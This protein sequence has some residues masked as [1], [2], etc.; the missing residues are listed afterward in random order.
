MDD[1]IRLLIK[2]IKTG[3][4]EAFKKLFLEYYD[5]LSNFAWRYIKSV[6]IA[7]E[8]VQEAFL[9]IWESREM[10]DSSKNIKSYLYQIVRNKALN[11]LKHKDVVEKYNTQI[12]WLNSVSI[13]QMHDFDEQPEFIEAAQEAIESLPDGARR[14]Y[15]LHRKDGLTYKEIAEVLDISIRTVESQM[16]RALEKLRNN[17]SEYLSDKSSLPV[18]E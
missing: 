16:S 10:L 6:H 2:K 8:L 15:K 12:D 5:P 4:K 11:H 9:S 13:S 14:I 3:D 7:E 18:K 1:D 17:L